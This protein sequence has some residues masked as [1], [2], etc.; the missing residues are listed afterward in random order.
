MDNIS[1][2]LL[3]I[4]EE[5]KI[6]DL[7]KFQWHLTN[8]V[9]DDK[10][11]PKS[12]LENTDR[13]DT[14]DK[15]V[16]KY[17][18][19]GAVEITLDILKKMNHNQLAESLRIK[20]SGDKCEE[21]TA[22]SPA[23]TCSSKQQKH[24][25]KEL[26]SSGGKSDFS[27]RMKMKYKQKFGNLCEEAPIECDRVP[28]KDTY[29]EVYMIKGCTGGVNTKHEVRQ[30]EE[31]YPKTEETP[32][33]LSDLFKVQ[34]I[35]NK[36]GT[37]VLT[38]GIAGVGKTVSVH[39]F[40][41]D[42]AE[43]KCN[44]DIDFI[45]YF[46][47]R[48]LNL[49]K[50][51]KYS[52]SKLL[53]YCHQEV[54]S[55]DE[56]EILN[57]KH[58]LLFILDG[59]DESRIPLDLHQKKVSNVNEKTTLDKLITNLI[60]GEL[61]PSALLWITSRPAAVSKINDQYFNLVTEIHGFNNPQKEEYFRKR[62]RDEDQ[63]SRIISH[64]KTARSLHILCHIP[65]VC[66]ISATV[67]KKMLKEGVDMKN[68]PT[69]LTEMYLHFLLFFT[70]QKTKK[71]NTKQSTNNAVSS[72]TKRAEVLDIVKLGKLAFLQLQKGQLLFYEKDLEECGIDVCEALVYSGICTQIFK[73]EGKIYSFVHLSFQEFLA[74]VFVFLTFR[75][76]GNPLLKTPMEKMKWKLK[77]RLCDL[78]ETA[79]D[80]ATMSENGHLDLFLRFLLGLSLE[81]NQRLLRSL[82]PELDIREESLEETV[83]YIKKTIK[84]T[85]SFEETINLFHC[86]SELKD[87][88]LISEIQT[89][90][91][92]GD[93]STQTLSSTQCSALVFVLLMS[94]EIQ[95]KFELKK[96]RSS[97]KGL[98]ELLP[99][100]KNTRRALLSGCGLT[101]ET[102][103]SLT[104]I[105]QTEN[106]LREL[107]MNNNDLQNSG[108]EQLCAG[109]KS[110]HCK[111][112]ILRLSGCGL[113]EE[114][115]KSL[116]SVLQTENSLRELKINNN[117][118]QNSG[119]EQL[120]A[121]LKS[122]HCK[123]EI[124][125]LSGCGLNE[126]S[127]KSLTSVLQT[128]N[129][130]RELKIN[131]NDLQNSGV[132]QL[133]AGLKSS[134]CKLEIL[135]LSG[136]GLNEE[137]CKSL[138]SVLQTENSLRELEMNNNDLQNSGVEQL[139][140]GLKSSHCKLEIHRLSGCGLNEESCKSLTSVLQTENSLRELEMNNNDL[141]NSGVE[142]L[143]AGLKSSY[144]KL[145]ILRL[146]GCGLNEESCKSL[147]SVLQTEN[148]LRE[149]EMN[150]ND[151]QNSGV[152]QLCAGL[153]SSQC[154]LE[155][156][157]LSGCG[158]NEE[159]CK[160][161][162]SVLQTENS[163]R[164]LEINNNDLQNSGV[165]Q[166]CAG[167]KNSH[168]KLEILRLSGCLVTEEGCSSLASALRSNPSHLKELDL[169]YNHPGE[170]GV[171]L[172]SVRLEDPHCRL[173]TLR[174]EYAGEIRIKPGLRKYACDLTLDPNTAH[175]RLSL[176]EGNRKVT[177]VEEQQSYPDHPERFDYWYQ[178]VCR[179]SLTGRC[180]WE[181]EWSGGGAG[182]SVT[183]KGIRR[184]GRSY[185]CW[186]G[187]NIKSW[188]LSCS[189]NRYTVWHNNKRTAISAPSSSNRVGVYL[190]WPAGTLSFYSVSSHT[191]TLTH[192]HTLHS[193]FTE[194]LYAAFWVYYN[195]SVCV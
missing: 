47:F 114:S 160:S 123:L 100:L 185:D 184:K 60:N 144:C 140:A 19:D 179:E 93:L 136:C 154:K 53:L 25:N 115:C 174:V 148:S 124:L 172:L 105:L 22:N 6:E 76:E 165:E 33:T 7:K 182:I 63:A 150:N 5:L 111:L 130:L 61:L 117:D 36:Q 79:V 91:N 72:E 175:T 157:R 108:V 163:L 38:L 195:S 77:H 29:T 41:L 171:K 62:I 145:E 135:R 54:H 142:Q 173:D 49:I 81:S 162:T 103:K 101:E 139:C 155:I 178:V 121:G 52:L 132:E 138:K 161:L 152:E 141:Q 177:C 28:I 190:D 2:L 4:L 66:R 82:H 45:M 75:G 109:L 51:E 18:P 183:Y 73:Q 187:C 126:E 46:P 181:V 74:A 113:N 78:L 14:V 193:T 90:L 167:L 69:T 15:M 164:E 166:L 151:L 129:S 57:E 67:F 194:P 64:I 13:L 97:D 84:R 1:K 186:F 11:I 48:E 44:Q 180:Y 119:V 65:V 99:V 12:H 92:S 120:C 191:H 116:T 34:S 10:C 128:E 68:A 146:S 71:Y 189:D 20:H 85:K 17:D 96:F 131:N 21:S 3:D 27:R 104:S 94:E 147:T 9:E 188:K 55:G 102:C 192:L 31:F 16:Q 107:E 118:L 8:S 127:C 70:D 50:D 59:L 80:K 176:S 137:S 159:S 30:V 39:K 89:F 168:C 43:E 87:N 170:S 86:L 153:K 112:E 58:Q 158:L 32:V 88:S 169:T 56:K 83:N 106:S 110:S 143:C 37:K 95:E 122:S 23:A 149:L 133:C 35:E 125:R 26:I 40:I 42:W 156:L 134:Q 98:K 24:R